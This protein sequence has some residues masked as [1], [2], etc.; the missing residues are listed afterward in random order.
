MCL[1]W[2]IW[3]SKSQKRYAFNLIDKTT[4]PRIPSQKVVQ[5]LPPNDSSW[6]CCSVFCVLY[7]NR[8]VLYIFVSRIYLYTPA[9]DYSLT[10]Q[11]NIYQHS[12]IYICVVFDARRYISILL[13]LL[14]RN[15]GLLKRGDRPTLSS[16]LQSSWRHISTTSSASG[17][18]TVILDD[19][20]VVFFSTKLSEEV[21][22]R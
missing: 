18:L 19:T 21:C 12:N 9:S 4:Y 20:N 8:Q 10:I 17:V 14:L 15:R 1:L 2:L 7:I 16:L 22:E 6:C 13:M 3:F 5:P 11:S